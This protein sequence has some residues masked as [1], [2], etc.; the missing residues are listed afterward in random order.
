MQD[1]KQNTPVTATEPTA[2][3]ANAT[4]KVLIVEDDQFLANAYRV[5]LTKQGFNI[6]LAGNGVEALEILKSFK[7]DVIITDLV[8]PEMDGFGL[9]QSV[10]TIPNTKAIP[11]VVSSSLG[12]KEDLERI[13]NLGAA[14][15]L[16]K[17]DLSLND[18][19]DKINK[20]SEGANYNPKMQ[21]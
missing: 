4:K 14:D 2:P 5:K 7:P 11:V 12:Q 18:L 9:L 10:K 19:I 3:V 1:D 21:E 20:I 16:V 17:S 15:Y 13:W 6:Q 8:M